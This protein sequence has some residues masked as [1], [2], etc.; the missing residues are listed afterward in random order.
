M[1]E[2]LIPHSMAKRVGI[3]HGRRQANGVVA[4][5]G[6]SGWVVAVLGQASDHAKAMRAPLGTP[7]T[8]SKQQGRRPAY[9]LE[10]SLTPGKLGG[11]A[12]VD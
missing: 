3:F 8:S 5:R 6:Y 11:E 1:V 4:R 9:R 10:V 12:V 2:E 7:S